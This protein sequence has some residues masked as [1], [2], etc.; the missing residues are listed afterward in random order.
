M[1]ATARDQAN[2]EQHPKQHE[3]VGLQREGE[4]IRYSI[5][6]SGNTAATQHIRQPG[7]RH[8]RPPTAARPSGLFCGRY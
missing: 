1:S 3:D 4:P 8:R 7:Q 5:R 6:E 2:A